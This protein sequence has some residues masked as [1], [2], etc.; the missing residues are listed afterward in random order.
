MK[1]TEARNL[2]HWFQ[3]LLQENISPEDVDIIGRA[4]EFRQAESS[5]DDYN[6][7]LTYTLGVAETLFDLQVDTDTLI[8]GIYMMQMLMVI[9]KQQ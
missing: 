4:F 6:E 9:V 5:A 1:N 8:A 2:E 3:K 7:Q